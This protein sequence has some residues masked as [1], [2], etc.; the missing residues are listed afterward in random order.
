MKQAMPVKSKWIWIDYV[1]FLLFLL[2]IYFAFLNITP[3]ERVIA[4]LSAT[5]QDSLWTNVF[6][7]IPIM[8]EIGS[9]I[10]KTIIWTMGASMWVVIQIIETLPIV[11]FADDLLLETII[12][13]GGKNKFDI[14]DND[15]PV[16]KTAKRIYNRLPFAVIRNLKYAQIFTYVFDF[17]LVITV[18]PPIQ[19]GLADFLFAIATGNYAVINGLN[20]ALSVITLFACEMI[21]VLIIYSNKLVLLYKQSRGLI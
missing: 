17:M 14:S 8:K 7:G 4:A 21:A 13:T 9:F 12:R 18:Y 15:D 11:I 19:G 10:G 5:T 2:G 16:M 3:Y 6:S 20:L 1:Y